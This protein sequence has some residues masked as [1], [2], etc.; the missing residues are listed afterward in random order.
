MNLRWFHALLILLSAALAVLFG[1]WCLALYGREHGAGSLLAFLDEKYYST[2]ESSLAGGILEAVGRTFKNDTR[3]FVYPLRNTETGK[4]TTV[5]NVEV[6]MHLSKLYGYLVDRE[7]IVP[8]RGY[9]PDYLRIFS[10]EV[11]QRIKQ[12]KQ[13]FRF[14]CQSVLNPRRIFVE[15]RSHHEPIMLHVTQTA[16]QRATADGMQSRQQIGGPHGAVDQIA[17]DQHGPL[18]AD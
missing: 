6:A 12:G 1:V 11:A 4:L 13:C 10:R 5:E 18:I 15:V 9:N 14:G 17:D 16:E 7:C 2:L 3:F 8:I